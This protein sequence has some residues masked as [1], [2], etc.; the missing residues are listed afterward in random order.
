VTHPGLPVIDAATLRERVGFADLIEP[1]AA[2]F[3]DSSAGQAENGLIIL[4]PAE[5][6]E[7]G[8]VYIKA[9]ALRGHRVFVTK[10]SPWFARNTAEHRPQGGF[11]AVFDSSTGHTLAIL[12]DQHYL[13]DIRTAAA[14]ALAARYLCPAR[15]ETAA[16]LGSGTQAYWQ[17]LALHRER[18]FTQLTIWA[19]DSGKAEILRSRLGRELPSVHLAVTADRESAV[20][21]ADAVITAT[22]AREPLVLGE[23][24]RAGQHITAV[25]ADD[26]TKCELDGAALRK[27]RVFVD[28][29]PMSEHN[30]DVRHAIQ[31][32]AYSINLL[33][34]EIGDVVSGRL[35][36]RGSA[37]DITIAKFVGLGAQDLAAA[38]VA[39]SKLG[40]L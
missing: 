6:R 40:L 25:G 23:W 22:P 30:G 24:L 5:T 10:V 31:N 18:P 3:R 14:G 27:A 26:P 4:F 17:T 38:E 36:G 29:V 19:R 2:A 1:V 13:S 37:G 12:D 28:S 11:I 9:G 16:V 21:Q 35:R 39:L 8:D 20:R 15:V 32:D 7:A 34:G 33:A